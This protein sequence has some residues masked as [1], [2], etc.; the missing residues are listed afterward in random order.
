MIYS[1]LL[2]EFQSNVTGLDWNVTAPAVKLG[3]GDECRELKKRSQRL[4]NFI[5]QS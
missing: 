3:V 2:T 4:H 1:S 5:A